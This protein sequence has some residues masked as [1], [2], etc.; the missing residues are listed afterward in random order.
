MFGPMA[1]P[2]DPDDPDDKPAGFGY[3]TDG[4]YDM[5]GNPIP[6]F[7][8]GTVDLSVGF[9]RLGAQI[10]YGATQGIRALSVGTL[11]AASVIFGY[12]AY[13]AEPNSL[14]QSVFIELSV[15]VGLFMVAPLVFAAIEWGPKVAWLGIVEGSGFFLVFSTQLIGMWQG[16]FAEACRGL[17]LVADLEHLTARWLR[18]VSVAVR[19]ARREVERTESDDPDLSSE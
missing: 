16:F 6:V 14:T 13:N 15:G 5:Y 2:H 19:R 4:F 10:A 8:A 1:P 11:L 17:L 18:V 3:F 9:R 7:G 12:I